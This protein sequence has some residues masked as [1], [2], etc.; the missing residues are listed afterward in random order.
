MDARTRGR[1]VDETVAR[2]SVHG[3]IGSDDEEDPDPQEIY[4]WYAVG[5]SGFEYAVKASGEPYIDDAQ[6]VFLWGRTCSG[7]ACYLDG[8]IEEIA[9]NLEWVE[10]AP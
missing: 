4:E 2:G 10:V 6:G 9:K 8:W 5:D 1:C 3:S 7:Q